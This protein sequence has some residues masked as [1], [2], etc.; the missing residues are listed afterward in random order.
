MAR[1]TEVGVLFDQYEQA[2]QDVCDALTREGF[3]ADLNKPYS[4]VAG[5]L[6]YSAHRHGQHHQIPYLELEIRQDLLSS[7]ENIQ[8]VAQRIAR[9]LNVFRPQ[10]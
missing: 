10:D 1:P 5:E 9:A 2:A 4:G 8:S 3:V 7:S 6:M